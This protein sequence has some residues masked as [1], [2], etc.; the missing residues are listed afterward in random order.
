MTVKEKKDKSFTCHNM[1]GQAPSVMG[2][3]FFQWEGKCQCINECIRKN[4]TRGK[5]HAGWPE[6]KHYPPTDSQTKERSRAKEEGSC[7]NKA[8]SKLSKI[9]VPNRQGINKALNIPLPLPLAVFVSLLMSKAWHARPIKPW[10]VP[11]VM[12]DQLHSIVYFHLKG[13]VP[14]SSCCTWLVCKC[15]RYYVMTK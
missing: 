4:Q 12:I 2:F 15:F 10:T 1:I 6:R 7:Q 5:V 9:K 3:L 11:C 8:P 13:W 14:L